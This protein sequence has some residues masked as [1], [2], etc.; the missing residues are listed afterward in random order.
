MN[1][2]N[3][4][5][6]SYSYRHV[7]RQDPLWT[8]NPL[9]GNGN[10][11]TQYKWHQQLLALGWT[12]EFSSNLVN[13]VRFGFNRDYAHSDPNGRPS[14]TSEAESAIGLTRIPAGPM[15]PVCPDIFSAV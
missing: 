3:Q 6:G 7:D 4:I 15:T 1:A 14:R 11:A 10:F 2:K 5:F 9:I 13:D 12:H 8:G